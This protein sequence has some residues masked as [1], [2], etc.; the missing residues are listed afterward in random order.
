MRA[1]AGGSRGCRDAHP[2]WSAACDPTEARR[3][4][5]GRG[6]ASP[7]GGQ[8]LS[9]LRVNRLNSA[10]P[11]TPRRP[12]RGDGR[13]PRFENEVAR[14]PSGRRGARVGPRPAACHCPPNARSTHPPS[15]SP[16]SD[17]VFHLDVSQNSSLLPKPNAIHGADPDPTRE[18]PNQ[19]RGQQVGG[20][21]SSQ[22][23][24]SSHVHPSL[25]ITTA[26]LRVRQRAVSDDSDVLHDVKI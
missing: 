19:H 25:S 10:H 11:P 12:L 24:L 2:E 15:A 20:S 26:G 6:F 4:P 14:R 17:A 5:P 9:H 23:L 16:D 7:V 21:P 13:R 8:P 3:R 1:R 18:Q 22:V